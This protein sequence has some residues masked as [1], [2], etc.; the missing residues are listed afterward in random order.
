MP[1]TAR[2]S[3]HLSSRPVMSAQRSRMSSC[4]PAP[5]REP[6]TFPFKGPV[7]ETEHF[8]YFQFSLQG[9]PAAVLCRRLAR[10][11]GIRAPQQRRIPENLPETVLTDA[12][13]PA[14]FLHDLFFSSPCWPPH[15]F[16]LFVSHKVYYLYIIKKYTHT[17]G[18]Q[19]ISYRFFFY[20]T[21]WMPNYFS[22]KCV[23]S[24]IV[25]VPLAHSLN[26]IL[27]NDLD[28]NNSPQ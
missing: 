23:C 8:W 16:P 21:P 5:T 9:F 19:I 25:C 2:V 14:L 3:F 13:I 18:Y 12:V 7:Q 11:P 1:Q 27:P 28:V 22:I 10:V 15:E 4:A 17:Q 20:A 6:I 26:C 24:I